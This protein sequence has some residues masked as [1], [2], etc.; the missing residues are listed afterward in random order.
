MS[1]VKGYQYQEG[2]IVPIQDSVDYDK[3]LFEFISQ[4]IDPYM[5]MFYK[6]DFS[7]DV[8]TVEKTLCSATLRW[9]Y[10]NTD[11]PFMVK[12][13]AHLKDSVSLQGQ[14]REYAPPF[15]SKLLTRIRRGKPATRF[16]RSIK[17]SIARSSPE[18]RVGFECINNLKQLKLSYSKGTTGCGKGSLFRYNLEKIKIRGLFWLC[19]ITAKIRKH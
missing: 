3:E 11:H 16:T 12:S 9:C 7:Q 14:V 19:Y 13:I 4:S 2:R 15:S 1:T 6:L 8:S 5:E 17:M 18:V 10:L